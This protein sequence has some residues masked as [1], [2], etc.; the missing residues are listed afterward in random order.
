MQDGER[1]VD[2][3]FPDEQRREKLDATTW[4]V[5]LLPFEFFGNK[6]VV[7]CTMGLDP[8]EDGLHISA[9]QLEITGLPKEF[10]IDGKVNLGKAVQADPGLKPPPPGFIKF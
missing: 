7:Y 3:T 10:N 6:V 2:V 5:Q 8:Q 1:I 9:K 4:R